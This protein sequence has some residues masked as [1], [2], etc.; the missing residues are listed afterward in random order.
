MNILAISGSLREAST[1][2]A[3]L[4]ALADAAPEGMEITLCEKIGQLPIFSP[5]LEGPL[6]PPIV[7][8]FAVQIA[9]AEALIIACPEYVHALPGG[10][11]NAIDWLVSGSEIIAKP[12]F[13]AQATSRGKDVL[14]DLQ[15]VL[16]TVSER[17]YPAPM[18]CVPLLSKTPEDIAK[19]V[20]DPQIRTEIDLFLDAVCRAVMAQEVD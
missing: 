5:D 10:F 14:A 12:I 1:N 16:G 18:L 13:L 8:E 3:L 11:K 9:A 20:Q 2:T 19:H 7:A 17:F 4:R 15:R 6:R